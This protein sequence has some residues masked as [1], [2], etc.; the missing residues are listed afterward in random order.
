MFQYCSSLQSVPLF[1]TTNMTSMSYMFYLE[2]D[3]NIEK[4][5]CKKCVQIYTC[6]CGREPHLDDVRINTCKKCGKE[7]YEVEKEN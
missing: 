3:Y 5:L 4:H 2:K 6:K 7:L 1:N